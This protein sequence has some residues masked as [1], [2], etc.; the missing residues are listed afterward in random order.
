[1][2]SLDVSSFNHIPE[3]DISVLFVEFLRSLPSENIHKGCSLISTA[4]SFL[5]QLTPL[6]RTRLAF[7]LS[8]TNRDQE[9]TEYND[10]AYEWAELLFWTST[11]S[12]L[13]R[14]SETG[15]KIAGKL[16]ESQRYAELHPN[17]DENHLILPQGFSIP[18]SETV[19]VAGR[20]LKDLQIIWSWE[21]AE[22]SWRVYEVRLVDQNDHTDSELSFQD[23]T[24]AVE[25]IVHGR[26]A[27]KDEVAS[28]DGY[29]DRYDK[30]EWES[31]END[32][33]MTKEIGESSSSGAVRNDD[34]YYRRY[35]NIETAIPG[36]DLEKVQQTVTDTG[37]NSPIESHI[38]TSI[39]NLYTLAKQTGLSRQSFEIILDR[40]MNADM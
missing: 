18:D 13:Q 31:A 29:W 26:D 21:E 4:S 20:V 25:D 28:E 15:S 40:A 35:E 3:P 36:D 32:N 7:N 11:D 24:M 5:L 1:M 6:L 2:A 19:L 16:Y 17:F 8:N 38:Y 39:K 30:V 34:E 22:K 10:R 33:E 23:W 9:S 14:D 37:M 12:P 27:L